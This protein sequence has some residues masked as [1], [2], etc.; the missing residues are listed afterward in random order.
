MSRSPEY[1]TAFL[2]L[3]GTKTQV[4]DGSFGSDIL[5]FV[6]PVGVAAARLPE[7]Y[8]EALSYSY[9]NHTLS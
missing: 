7:I 4:R 1:I 5:D 6:N 2:G 9:G 3:F 8:Y